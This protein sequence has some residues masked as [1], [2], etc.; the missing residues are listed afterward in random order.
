MHFL[1]LALQ[2]AITINY[3]RA[4]PKGGATNSR[5]SAAERIRALVADHSP[6]VIFRKARVAEITDNLRR[7]DGDWNR[8]RVRREGGSSIR[9]TLDTNLRAQCYFPSWRERFSPARL[10]SH[11]CPGGAIKAHGSI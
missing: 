9:G 6:R 7:Y 5:R 3:Q 4:T 10:E 11:N 1:L 2:R 8:V